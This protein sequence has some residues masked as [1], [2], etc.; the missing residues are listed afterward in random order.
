MI[1]ILLDLF[2]RNISRLIKSR[3]NKLEYQK[4]LKE[5]IRL[6]PF[7]KF[8]KCLPKNL[9]LEALYERLFDFNGLLNEININTIELKFCST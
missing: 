7:S 6:V 5:S 4:K 9:W 8:S 3:N 2:S 1:G